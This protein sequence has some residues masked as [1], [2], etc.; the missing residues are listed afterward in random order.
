MSL[1][2]RMP[3]R[4]LDDGVDS[5]GCGIYGPGFVGSA[6]KME[7]NGDQVLPFEARE[8]ARLLEQ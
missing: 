7:Y 6:F 3:V 8:T 4:L 2:G 5:S 1:V